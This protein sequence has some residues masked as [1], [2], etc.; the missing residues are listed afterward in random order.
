MKE[1]YGGKTFLV[2]AFLIGLAIFTYPTLSDYLARRNVI[3]MANTYEQT[4]T[5]LRD[6]EIEK[7]WEEARAY[8]DSLNG[9]PVPDPF[10]PGSGRVLPENYLRVLNLDDGVMG[11]VDI[12]NIDVYLPIYHGVADEVLEKGAGHIEQTTLPIGGIGNLSII[13]AHTGFSGAAMFDRLI[14]MIEG[15]IF[16]IHVLDETFTYQVDDIR[17]ILPDQVESLF[18]VEGEDYV[19]LIT[20][21][22]Y[23]VNSHRLLVRGTRI[24]NL[25]NETRTVDK[26]PFP[27]RLLWMIVIAVLLFSLLLIWNSRQE[28]NNRQNEEVGESEAQMRRRE[29]EMRMKEV[30]RERERRKMR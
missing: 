23:G 6:E 11:Y 10:I 13:T 8:N 18:P 17:V 2:V 26:V 7:M 30:A 20:C 22:P 29:L 4:L 15:D 24:E 28:R 12:P 3:H 5:D 16:K 9:N 19:T 14:E 21:T 1:K 25:S 27:Y